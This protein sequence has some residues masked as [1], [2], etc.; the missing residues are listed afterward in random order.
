LADSPVKVAAFI[1]WQNVYRTAR[2]AFSL[3]EMPNEHGNFSPFRLARILAAG[4]GRGKSAELAFVEI[5][6]GLPSP[7]HDRLGY[8]ANRR[9]TAAWAAESN[10]L[11]RPHMRPLRYSRNFPQEPAVEKG[12]DVQLAVNAV[13]ATLRGR[14]EVAIIF[15]HDSDLLPVPETIARLVGTRRVETASWAG[16]RFRIRL[17][18]KGSIYHHEIPEKVFDLVATPINFARR[19]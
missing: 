16:P 6:R 3:R 10:G 15:S 7:R 11:I 5:F 19:P 4:N 17:R 1:D 12:V 13:E 2:D 9:Q 8:A 14:C 18:P